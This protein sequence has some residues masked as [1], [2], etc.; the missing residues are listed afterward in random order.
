[1]KCRDSGY[2]EDHAVFALYLRVSDLFRQSLDSGPVLHAS[3][4]DL[5]LKVFT[6]LLPWHLLRSHS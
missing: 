6:T 4:S 1:M 3:V 2:D 5:S